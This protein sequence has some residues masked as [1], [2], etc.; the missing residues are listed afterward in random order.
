MQQQVNN[1]EEEER[2]MVGLLPTYSGFVHQ[3]DADAQHRIVIVR[4]GWPIGERWERGEWAP[5]AHLATL[6]VGKVATWYCATQFFEGTF[7]V[8]I[9]WKITRDTQIPTT[10]AFQHEADIRY[11]TEALNAPTNPPTT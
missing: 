6:K 4:S 2:G 5:Y 9:C 1:F 3:Y 7:P 11:A 10:V 8:D